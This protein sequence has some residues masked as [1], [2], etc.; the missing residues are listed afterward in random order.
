MSRSISLAEAVSKTCLSKIESLT[1][2]F[3]NFPKLARS[4]G[5]NYF[6]C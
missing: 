1:R 3:A 5:W 4:S 2:G 6:P